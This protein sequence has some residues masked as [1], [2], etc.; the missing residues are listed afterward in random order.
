MKRCLVLM[1]GAVFLFSGVAFAADE[2]KARSGGD[3]KARSGGD[4]K[5][6]TPKEAP[7]KVTKMKA[8][9]TVV[10]ISDSALKLERDVKGNKEAMDFSL[11]KAS[12]DVAAGDKVNVTYVVKDGKNV[13]EKVAK[14]KEKKETPKK[15]AAPGQP[16]KARSG[17]DVKAKSGGEVQSRGK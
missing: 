14:V 6:R 10:S 15:A 7:P 2:V 4:V 1:L 5:A 9:G 17:G 11:A 12:P 8:S 16:V 13:A 3:V